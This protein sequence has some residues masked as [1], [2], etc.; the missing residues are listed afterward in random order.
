MMMQP[1]HQRGHKTR[2][3]R[4]QQTSELGVSQ[5]LQSSLPAHT[6]TSDPRPPIVRGDIQLPEWPGPRSRLPPLLPHG[7][8]YSRAPSPHPVAFVTGVPGKSLKRL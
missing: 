2:T 4:S 6:L 8:S 7:L 5:G 1:D 3:E